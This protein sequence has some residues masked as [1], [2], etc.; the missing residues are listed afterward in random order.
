MNRA[1]PND[2]HDD[3][4]DREESDLSRRIFAVVDLA[5]DPEPRAAIGLSR[6]SS[7]MKT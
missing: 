1:R 2:H 4:V 3:D 7:P 5:R 6:A